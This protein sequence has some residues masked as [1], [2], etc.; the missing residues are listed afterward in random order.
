MQSMVF[1]F[2]NGQIWLGAPSS[3]TIYFRILPL[4]GPAVA[5]TQIALVLILTYGN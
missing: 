3:L 5:S 2:G 1:T 4:C